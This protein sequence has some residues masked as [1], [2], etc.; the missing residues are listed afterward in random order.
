MYVLIHSSNIFGKLP[1]NFLTMVTPGELKVSG[2]RELFSPFNFMVFCLRP[3]LDHIHVLLRIHMFKIKFS[4]YY[5]TAHSGG[6]S[7]PVS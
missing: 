3:I 6:G 1:M 7:F 5:F 2:G 4:P